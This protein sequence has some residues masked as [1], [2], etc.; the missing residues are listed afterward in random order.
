[1]YRSVPP[2]MR[3]QTYGVRDR[4]FTTFRSEMLPDDAIRRRVVWSSWNGTHE[5][6]LIKSRSFEDGR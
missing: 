2:K 3:E 5:K 6:F 4:L 1:M